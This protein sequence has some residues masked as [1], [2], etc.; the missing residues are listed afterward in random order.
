VLQHYQQRRQPDRQATV[1]ITDGL[2]RLFA[3][4]FSPLVVGRNLGLM[5]M[6]N[7]PLMRNMLAE[8]TLGWVKR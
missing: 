8:R 4:R 2:V 7:L 6:D 5:A 3:N 1:G